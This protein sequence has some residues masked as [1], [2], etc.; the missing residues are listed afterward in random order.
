VCNGDIGP[1]DQVAIVELRSKGRAGPVVLRDYRDPANPTTVCEFGK[2]SGWSYSLLDAQHLLARNW[3]CYEGGCA[4]AV[5]D[6]PAVRYHWFALTDTNDDYEELVGVSPNLDEVA[7]R[8]TT[9]DDP[10]VGEPRSVYVTRS[11]GT[12]LIGHL[13][14]SGGGFCGEGPFHS[15]Y[16]RS[17]S[18]FYMLDYAGSPGVFQ[19]FRGRQRVFSLRT[20]SSAFA[21]GPRS[22]IWSSVADTLYYLRGSDL[23]RWTADAGPQRFMPDVTWSS[24]TISPDDHYLAYAASGADGSSDTYLIDLTATRPESQ[25]IARKREAPRFLT[26]TQLWLQ[27]EPGSGGCAGPEPAPPV[28]YDIN[29]GAEAPSIIRRVWSTWPAM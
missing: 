3:D 25:L 20:K 29:E 18:Y 8:S 24:A 5:I 6:L 1:T 2:A 19:I 26:D 17:G 22:P 14:P 15:G 11:D 12:E 28:I 13:P 27:P 9:Y 4:Y 21:E 16:A 23:W 7:W 10:R